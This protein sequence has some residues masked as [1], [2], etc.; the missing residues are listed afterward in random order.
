MRKKQSRSFKRF[1][2]GS[3]LA[4]AVAGVSALAPRAFATTKD[5]NNT[6]LS[7]PGSWVGGVTPQTNGDV[8]I[9]DSTFATGVPALSLGN[10][11][12]WLGIQLLNPVQAVTINAG[13]TLT[14][15]VSGIDTTSSGFALTLNPNIS[16]SASQTWNVVGALTVGGTVNVGGGTL[17]ITSGSSALLNAAVSNGSVV[18]SG[19]GATSL[20]G[21]DSLAQLVV[22]GG[23]ATLV[24]T[25]TIGTV[26]LSGGLTTIAAAGGLGSGVLNLSGGS[27]DISALPVTLSNS[28]INLS[29]NTTYV[30][31]QGQALSVSG[32]NLAPG[33]TLTL[34]GGKNNA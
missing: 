21:N 10:D 27:I 1:Q 19:T 15:G 28:V 3:M 32:L 20:G 9:F 7:L 29:G 25:K 6:N 14:L 22:S 8:A 30:G 12:N 17:S 34:G 2:V 18:I 13:N 4:I 26:T 23:H 11:V 16:L 31:S 33:S 5:N 24:G